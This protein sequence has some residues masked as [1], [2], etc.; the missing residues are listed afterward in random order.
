MTKTLKPIKYLHTKL[1]YGN[2]VTLALIALML[3]FFA[4]TKWFSENAS[5]SSA[6]II[7]FIQ[8]IPFLLILPGIFK[9]Y[10][11]SYSWLCFLLLFYFVFAIERCFLSTASVKEYVFVTLTIVLFIAAMMTS[12]WQ[13]RALYQNTH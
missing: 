10:Y 5:L 7:W 11:R 2:R 9:H 3:S 8:S 4:I 13:Q 6:I 12:R 1:K